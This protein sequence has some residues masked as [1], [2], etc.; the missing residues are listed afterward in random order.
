MLFWIVTASAALV[1]FLFWS[2]VEWRRA[3]GIKQHGWPWCKHDDDPIFVYDR[4]H[5]SGVRYWRW[6]PVCGDFREIGYVGTGWPED[7]AQE[8]KE[9]F[10]KYNI[11]HD[12]LIPYVAGPDSID[13]IALKLEFTRRGRLRAKK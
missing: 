10:E 13:Y 1:A 11:S 9:L 8:K 4:Q 3:H 7:T 2:Y 12:Q 6:C 5:H